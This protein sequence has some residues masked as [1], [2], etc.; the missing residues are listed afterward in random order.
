M[1]WK[2]SPPPGFD[3]AL[4]RRTDEDGP[5]VG[6]RGPHRLS[7][8]NVGRAQRLVDP[9]PIPRISGGDRGDARSGT[10]RPYLAPVARYRC[11]RADSRLREGLGQLEAWY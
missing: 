9:G 6:L 2:I 3:G 11:R 8:T 5:S 10:A 4:L 1:E 7:R